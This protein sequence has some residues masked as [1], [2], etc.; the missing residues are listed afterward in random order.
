M[1]ADFNIEMWPIIVITYHNVKEKNFKIC[2]NEYKID[3]LN[4]LDKF[5][6]KETKG[7]ILYNFNE[8]KKT[9]IIQGIKIMKFKESISNLIDKNV[10]FTYMIVRNNIM[11]NTIKIIAKSNKHND[12]LFFGKKVEDVLQSIYNQSNEVIATSV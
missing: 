1:F 12:K 7:I 2:F 3:F 6:N 8:I 11:R 5:K 4:L 9:D 10:L